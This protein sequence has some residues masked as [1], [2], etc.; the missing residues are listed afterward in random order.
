MAQA[1]AP[2]DGDPTAPPLSRKWS[3][4]IAGAWILVGALVL[5]R[6]SMMAWL[7]ARELPVYMAGDY[8]AGV[9]PGWAYFFIFAPTLAATVALF[10]QAAAFRGVGQALTI[11]SVMLLLLAYMIGLELMR[12]APDVID[13]A[14]LRD[15]RKYIL[16]LDRFAFEEP[17]PIMVIYRAEGTVGWIWRQEYG[18][19][20]REASWSDGTGDFVV[21]PDQSLLLV[22]R[23]GLWTD[24]FR[25]AAP[26][27]EECGF[28]PRVFRYGREPATV[29]RAR[30]ERI[31]RYTGLSPQ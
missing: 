14:T 19:D 24:C 28:R 18:L 4:A 31:A 1:P 12:G 23:R 17:E 25:L 7:Y 2:S 3:L 15:G 22:R 8:P 21:S 29:I 5:M 16:I 11:V 9:S 27:L 6:E 13:S 10:L 30:S 26:R 20:P